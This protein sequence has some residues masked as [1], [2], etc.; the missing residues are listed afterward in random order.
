MSHVDRYKG[1]R[2]KDPQPQASLSTSQNRTVMGIQPWT[3]SGSSRSILESKTLMTNGGYT[4]A[5][6]SLVFLV[7][8]GYLA[9]A[10]A[11]NL[12]DCGG[13]L[14]KAQEAEWNATNP[15]SPAPKLELSYEQCVAKCGRGIGYINLEAF[16]QS[17]GAWFLPWISLMF[18]IPFGAECKRYICISS[19]FGALT[20][21]SQFPSK[22]F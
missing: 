10:N 16:S 3:R 18:Q 22:T 14:K 4:T 7:F 15:T 17:F 6:I 5:H 11:V 8:M 9:T 12:A 19:P 20:R 1:V 2:Y 21:C 13:E